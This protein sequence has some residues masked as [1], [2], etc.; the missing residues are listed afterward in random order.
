MHRKRILLTLIVAACGWCRIA[1]G[2]DVQDVGVDLDKFLGKDWFGV[3]MNGQK[4][5]YAFTDYARITY[6]DRPA[7]SSQM[8]CELNLAVMGSVQKMQIAERHVYYLEG[9]LAESM[10]SLGELQSFTATVEGDKMLLVSDLGGMKREKTLDAPKVTLRDELAPLRL[11]LGK[12][13]VGDTVDSPTF[14]PMHARTLNQTFTVTAIKKAVIDGV[15]TDAYELDGV[16]KEMNL[17][18]KLDVAASGDLIEMTM[19][20]G[21]TSLVLKREDEQEAKK[22]AGRPFEALD[23]SAIKPTGRMPRTA[24]LEKLRLR[25]SDLNKELDLKDDERQQFEKQ[26][27][28]SVIATLRKDPVPRKTPAIP[29]RDE[30]LQDFLKATDVCQSDNEEIIGKARE[31]IGKETNALRATQAL[32]LWVYAN[33]KKE[34]TAVMSNAL[35]TLHTLRGDCGEHAALLVGLCRAAGIPARTATGL[36]YSSSFGAFGGHAWAEVYLGRWVAVDPTFG[37]PIANPA[38]IKLAGEDLLDQTR[39]LQTIGKMKIEVLP[40]E[41]EKK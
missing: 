23:V 15:E 36:A 7:F 26:D 31:I 6:K 3:Y 29:V 19:P 1:A 40:A 34:G 37:E 41:P 28:G 21:G 39:L 35:D 22:H 30:K 33:V 20:M 38:R 9:T 4:C 12:P 2:A 11:V 24:T 5:G 8:Q 17:K 10:S 16:V 32:C 18:M 13:K 14:N 25:L 27:D